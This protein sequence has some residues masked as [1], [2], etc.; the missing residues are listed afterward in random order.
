MTPYDFGFDVVTPYAS[1]WVASLPSST[2]PASC[3]GRATVASRSG[4]RPLY[5]AVPAAVTMPAVSIRSLSPIGTPCRG[6][7]RRPW[8]TSSASACASARARSAVTVT[9]A[10]SSGFN[11]SMRAKYASVT[12]TGDSSPPATAAAV[13]LSVSSVGSLTTPPVRGPAMPLRRRRA[14]SQTARLNV[15]NTLPRVIFVRWASVRC[16]VWLLMVCC[17]WG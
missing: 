6:P 16:A 13:S 2:L 8:R 11:F 10:V 5:A 1:S 15:S 4:T 7:R 17:E 14:E 12:S 3:K 9:N